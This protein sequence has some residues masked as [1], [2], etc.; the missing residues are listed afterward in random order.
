MFSIDF[1][2]SAPFLFQGSP[3]RYQG[4]VGAGPLIRRAAAAGDGGGARLRGGGPWLPG[5]GGEEHQPGP[6]GQQV[7]TEGKCVDGCLCMCTH[8]MISTD[9]TDERL[10]APFTL[11]CKHPGGNM[12]LHKSESPPGILN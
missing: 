5:A 10:F 6:G 4:N 8:R 1:R 12:Q 7:G 9:L 2:L 11:L 3:Q